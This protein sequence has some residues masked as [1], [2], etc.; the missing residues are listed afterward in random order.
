MTAAYASLPV[1]R[2]CFFDDC[3]ATA[4]ASWLRGRGLTS[5]GRVRGRDA[6]KVAA[7]RQSTADPFFSS[8]SLSRAHALISLLSLKS[9]GETSD[10]GDDVKAVRG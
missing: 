8:L 4:F 7:Q 6:T 9:R 1:K 3:P 5:Q 2:C 10:K